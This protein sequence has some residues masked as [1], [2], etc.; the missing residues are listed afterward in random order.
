MCYSPWTW[1]LISPS[2]VSRAQGWNFC[3]K[4][5]LPS[6]PDVAYFETKCAAHEGLKKDVSV[7]MTDVVS[8][9]FE[10]VTEEDP[11]VT[12]APGTVV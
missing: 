5:T 7:T 12:K 2:D 8:M 4:L 11:N 1:S 10:K 6:E 9:W 3:L